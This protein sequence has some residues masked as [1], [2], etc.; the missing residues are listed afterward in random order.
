MSARMTSPIALGHHSGEKTIS[1]RHRP[2]HAALE[3]ELLN[4]PSRLWFGIVVLLNT[5][6]IGALFYDLVTKVVS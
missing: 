5:L 1:K 3:R 6:I 4:G 2:S